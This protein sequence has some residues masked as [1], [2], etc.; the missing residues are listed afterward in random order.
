MLDVGATYV[1]LEREQGV[2]GR[3]EL[4]NVLPL[5]ACLL[6]S[7]EADMKLPI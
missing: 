7:D 6:V 4:S 3:A 1:V 2:R 5:S